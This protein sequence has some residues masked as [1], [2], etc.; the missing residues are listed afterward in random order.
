MKPIYF[1]SA[2]DW[3]RW[4]EKNSGRCEELLVGYFKLRARRPRAGRAAAGKAGSGALAAGEAATEQA[5]M[6]W[7][8]SVDQALCF[9]WI[10]GR[11]KSVDAMRYTIRFSPRKSASVW[12]TV[13]IRRVAE[14]QRQGLMQ[15]AGLAA[16]EARREN[17]SGVYSYE[18]R[19][20]EL[21]KAYALQLARVPPANE[22]FAAQAPS[23]R[24]AA[25]WWVISAKQEA[26][27]LRRLGTLIA[28]SQHGRQL[29]QFIRKAAVT[30]RA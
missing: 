22:F 2:T 13:N 10:D 24:R 16:F 4:L 14:L 5:V 7:P 20:A 1:S 17:R 9:G 30:K 26:T 6:T 8:E 28:D 29:K 25:I 21:P 19:P 11:R 18:Q 3:R 27:R 12:S 15:P 23:Y